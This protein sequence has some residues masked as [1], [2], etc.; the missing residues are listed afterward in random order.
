MSTQPFRFGEIIDVTITGLR[1]LAQDEY[2]LL[3]ERR[4]GSTEAL[5]LDD[6]T[7]ATRVTPAD[8]EPQPGDLWRDVNGTMWFAFADLDED[9]GDYPTLMCSQDTY[10]LGSAVEPRRVNHLYGPL[11]LVY[12]PD[13]PKPASA[14]CLDTDCGPDYVAGPDVPVGA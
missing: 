12:R 13:P 9:T 10:S 2:G 3:L 14:P 1:V 11:E 5:P 8:G 4:D 7:V 6:Q